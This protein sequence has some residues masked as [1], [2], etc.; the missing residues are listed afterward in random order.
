MESDRMK[1]LGETECVEITIPQGQQ[2]YTYTFTETYEE[3]PR[4]NY[5]CGH[6]YTEVV[7]T[8]NVTITMDDS[9]HEHVGMLCVY[10][11]EEKL[12]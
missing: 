1:M 10:I 4:I 9:G 11:P 3:P 6:D 8:T 2:S 12:N 5:R 7:T